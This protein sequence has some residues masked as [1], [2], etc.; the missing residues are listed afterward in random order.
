MTIGLRLGLS[1]AFIVGLMFLGGGAALYDMHSIQESVQRIHKFDQMTVAVSEANH[2]LLRFASDLRKLSSRQDTEQYREGALRIKEQMV[3]AL[4]AAQSAAEMSSG[5]SDQHPALLATL[6]FWRRLLPDYLDRTIRLAALGDWEAID[7]RLDSQLSPTAQVLN[8]SVAQID[9]EI[10]DQRRI[11]LA[12]IWGNAE[13]AFIHMMVLGS[14]IILMT[15]AIGYQLVRS[16]ATPLH[17]LKEAVHGLAAGNFQHR[18]PII[19]SDE[20]AAVSSAF[21]LAVERL[22]DLYEGLEQRVAQRTAQFGDRQAGCG[23]RQ[24]RQERIPREYEP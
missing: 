22:S 24:P 19:G 13:S 2:T 4:G 20:L 10:N 12:D 3:A 1:L 7:R 9:R 5:F 17:R 16:I 15:I 6:G 18:I 14:L 8:E 11:T 21:N 23:G